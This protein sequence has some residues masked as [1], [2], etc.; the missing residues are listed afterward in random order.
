M[1][2]EEP[3][4]RKNLELHGHGSYREGIIIRLTSFTELMTQKALGWNR[5]TPDSAE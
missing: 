5:G 4:V 3:L 1:N 2:T